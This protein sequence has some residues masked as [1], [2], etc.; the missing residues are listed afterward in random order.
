MFGSSL[1][2]L[3]LSSFAAAQYGYGDTGATT[4]AA[5]SATTGAAAV[6][7]SAPPNTNGHINVGVPRGMLVKVHTKYA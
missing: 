2:A 1:F 5:T 6:V 3:L 4:A 7:P